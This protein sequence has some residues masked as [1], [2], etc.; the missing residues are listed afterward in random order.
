MMRA[1]TTN[2]KNCIDDDDDDDEFISFITLTLFAR[3]IRSWACISCQNEMCTL[4]SFAVVFVAVVYLVDSIVLLVDV[5]P[6][7]TIC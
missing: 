2:D 6:H 1:M 4:L 3:Y 5:F 7:T